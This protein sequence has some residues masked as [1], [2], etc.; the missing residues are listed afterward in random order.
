ML[1]IENHPTEETIELYAL[2]RLAEELVPSLEEH[3]LV[4]ERCRNDLRKEDAFV[5]G[6]RGA[7]KPNSAP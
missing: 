1:T 4:C 7:L 2:D 5:Q 6:L 3:L